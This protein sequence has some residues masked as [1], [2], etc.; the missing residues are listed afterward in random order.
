MITFD[1]LEGN[2]SDTAKVRNIFEIVEER[3]NEYVY[4][5]AGDKN[6]FNVSLAMGG[7]NIVN[8]NT[9]KCT[10]LGW[11]APV[12][13]QSK[14]GELE[15][16][17]YM[18]EF[19]TKLVSPTGIPS[20]ASVSSLVSVSVPVAGPTTWYDGILTNVTRFDLGP[21]WSTSSTFITSMM[22]NDD[23]TK[24]MY[25]EYT[26]RKRLRVSTLSTPWNL[27]TYG[28]ITTFSGFPYDGYDYNGGA[29]I[30]QD[31]KHLFLFNAGTLYRFTGTTGFDVTSFSTT[32][33]QNISL[34]GTLATGA[35]TCFGKFEF[36]A[37]GLN[38]YMMNYT[39][40]RLYHW[41]LGT[42][43]DLTTASY[44]GFTA[45]AT[46]YNRAFKVSPDGTKMIV[47]VAVSTAQYLREFTL[48][49][50]ANDI[51][52]GLTAGTLSAAAVTSTGS[53]LLDTIY[54]AHDFSYVY[55]GGG[56]SGTIYSF[57][58]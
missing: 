47:S 22:F 18:L 36:T 31:G 25:Y 20:T 34:S 42:A 27:S 2:Y 57:N 33:D 24:M 44:Q 13:P 3:L 5:R 39:T 1:T 35:G 45:A 28:V 30:S 15:K 41:T 29:P 43:W 38:M 8:A 26:P 51:S 40:P 11:T 9:I 48:T 52:G 7:N 6:V 54:V 4:F 46:N 12:L 53:T 49:A 58:V 37:D 16:R 17:I 56:D 10:E 50:G 19:P 23:G 32:S 55:A 14:V 21:A